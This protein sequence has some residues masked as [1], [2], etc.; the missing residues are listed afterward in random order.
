M[1]PHLERL[2]ERLARWPGMA[3]CLV[4]GVDFLYLLGWSPVVDERPTFLMVGPKGVALAV[5]ALN[6]ARAEQVLGEAGR[7]FAWTDGEGPGQATAAALTTCGWQGGR[8]AFSDAGRFDHAVLLEAVAGVRLERASPILRPLRL[9]KDAA[10]QAQL[11]H[12]ARLCDRGME[13]GLKALRLGITEQE[14][15]EAV[16]QGFLLAGAD[17]PAFILVAF[18]PNTAEPH[19]QPDGTRLGPGPVLLDIGCYHAGYASDMTRMA[20]WG[21]PTPAFREAFATVEAAVEAGLSAVGPG[22]PC[23]AVDQAARSVIRAQ[24]MAERFVH[25]T[26]HGIGLEV[27]EAPDIVEGNREEQAV[28]MAFSVEPGVYFPG[29]FGIRLEEVV[30]VHEGGGRVLSRL[31]RD[32]VRLG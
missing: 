4:P 26:G 17:S 29:A 25:R 21:E 10:E 31:P 24:G 15:A 23:E 14:V 2:R 27:H 5:P 13:A 3:A 9:I 8:L 20:Y 16:R 32:L 18:G 19:H 7:V 1:H 12:S 11:A 30:L 22:K 6:A 28:G